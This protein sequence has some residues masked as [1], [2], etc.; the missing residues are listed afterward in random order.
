[1]INNNIKM[2]N[3]T[4]SPGI[5]C[6]V[7]DYLDEDPPIPNQVWACVSVFTP[8]SIKNPEGEV[9][10]T[11]HRARSFKIRGVYAT[12]EKADKR[13]K[14]ISKFD[15]RHNVFV[16]EVGKWLPWDDD[17]TNAEEAVYAEPKLNEMMKEYKESQDKAA[18][19]AEERK[20]KAHADANRRKKEKLRKEKEDPDEIQ[21]DIITKTVIEANITEST[22]TASEISS[23]QNKLNQ[24]TEKVKSEQEQLSQEQQNLVENEKKI[25]KIDEELEKAQQLYTELIK[26]YNRE[27]SNR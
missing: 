22:L 11:G 8:N 23:D 16:G 2:S 13:C 19:Y 14:E 1:M 12:K 6:S 24:L 25:T 26:K 20:M 18:E 4:A 10:D 3:K 21:N 9:I 15:P 5:P 7:E 17:A 27:K